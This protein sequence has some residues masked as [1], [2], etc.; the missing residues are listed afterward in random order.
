MTDFYPENLEKPRDESPGEAQVRLADWF[1][2]LVGFFGI[3]YYP[4][5]REAQAKAMGAWIRR[6]PALGKWK[7][8]KK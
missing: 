2:S 1:I 5:E 7:A 4:F 8:P 6:W 3:R